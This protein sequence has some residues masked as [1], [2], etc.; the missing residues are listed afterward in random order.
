VIVTF[1]L[2]KSQAATGTDQDCGPRRA[3]AYGMGEPKLTGKSGA[4]ATVCLL[5]KYSAAT[6][7][8]WLKPTGKM[9]WV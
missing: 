7:S 1:T 5:A 3:H 9:F 8:A 4:A 2:R 6:G